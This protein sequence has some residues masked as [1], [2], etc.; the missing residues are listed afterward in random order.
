[1]SSSIFTSAQTT[2]SPNTAAESAPTLQHFDP[3]M[4]DT[5]IDP[6]VDFHQYACGKSFAENP[7]PANEVAWGSASKLAIWNDT[8]LHQTLDDAAA[9][10]QGRGA[11]EQKIGDYYEA[12]MDEQKIDAAGIKP[13]EP[14]LNRIAAIKEKSEL[15]EVLAQLHTAFPAAWSGSDNQTN[16]ALFGF[17]PTPDYND[18]RQ[19]VA[20]VDQ[21]GIGLPGRDFYLNNDEK[22]QGI[23]AQYVA[24]I[25]KTLA[26]SGE[27]EAQAQQDAANILALET[28]LAKLQMDNISRR[29]PK[30]LNNRYT[31]AQLKA[32]T[33]SFDWDTYLK[34][35]AAPASPVYLVTTPAFFK[36]LEPLIQQQPLEIWQAYLRWHLLS[37]ASGYLSANFVNEQ[38]AFIK[39]LYGVQE[40]Q[41]RW[42]RCVAFT[43]RDLGEALGQAYVAR[44]FSPEAKARAKK[45]VNDI[46][47]ALG[48]DITAVDWMQPSTK[49][50]AHAKLAAVVDKIGYPD[51]WRDYSALEITPDSLLTN[52]ERATA[53]ESHRQMS[54]I[55]KPLDRAE[56]IMTPPTVD[57]YEDPQTNTINF[58]AGILHPPFFDASMPDSVNYGS[59]GAIMGH[60]TIHGFDDQGRKFDLNGNLHDWWSAADA[61]AYDQR[62]DCIAEEYTQMVPEAG[63]KQNGR[64]T[65]GEDTADNGGA[66]LALMALRQSLASQGQTLD[67][68]GQDGLTNLQRFFLAYASSWCEQVRPEAMRTAIL[69]NPHSMPKYRV[70]N[71]VAN[72][73]E[74]TKAFSC[75]AGQPMVHA[76]RCRVW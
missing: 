45:L 30:N 31:L 46:E 13:L 15:A 23:R 71:V 8:V 29:D 27:P 52:V 17:G 63:V 25:S 28:A 24:H 61:K 43:D 73:P 62:G 76:K 47:A 49:T 64:L 74:F 42:R 55:G 40:I 35:V 66:N 39:G 48:R 37:K 68:K 20:G 57:A 22:S 9:R 56:W 59:E 32:L 54:K 34:A 19:V 72:M 75:K 67:T 1:M 38:F 18:A 51:V 58:P 60:E 7:I 50:A 44:A 2:P 5:A 3:K 14:L 53:F 11:N 41:P 21:G 33:P 69:T 36:G 4:V 10:K 12:C 70:N 6:C 16:A 65:Q 26:M